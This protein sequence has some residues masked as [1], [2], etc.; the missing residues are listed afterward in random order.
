MIASAL[1]ESLTRRQVPQPSRGRSRGRRAGR[2]SRSLHGHG[3]RAGMSKLV[4]KAGCASGMPDKSQLCQ[5]PIISEKIKPRFQKSPGFLLVSLLFSPLLPPA[6]S[7]LHLPAVIH[8][9][10]VRTQR[11]SFLLAKPL[12]LLLVV[13]KSERRH[14]SDL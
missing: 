5:I 8:L 3:S 14:Q 9:F 2:P 13:I 6:F 4:L 11:G 7:P 12:E 10:A 1:S